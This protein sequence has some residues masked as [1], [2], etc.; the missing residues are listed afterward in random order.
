MLKAFD[1]CRLLHGASCL[2]GIKGLNPCAEVLHGIILRPPCMKA[3]GGNCLWE[4][5]FQ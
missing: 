3:E 2:M 1:A 4:V 5:A